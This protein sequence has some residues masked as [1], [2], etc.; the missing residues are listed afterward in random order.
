MLEKQCP[1]CGSEKVRLA[2][3]CDH[4]DHIQ[5]ARLRC[6]DCNEQS[7]L[8][9]ALPALSAACMAAWAEDADEPMCVHGRKSGAMCPHCL[10]YPRVA[11]P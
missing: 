5:N 6:R 2:V 3:D 10:M 11:I 8:I 1:K 7:P 4:R 9:Q